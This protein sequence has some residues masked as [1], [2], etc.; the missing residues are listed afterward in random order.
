M[1]RFTRACALLIAPVLA[2]VG[3]TAPAS[4]DDYSVVVT[5][6][7][8]VIFAD[9][10]EHPFNYSVTPPPDASSWKIELAI[11]APDGTSGGSV[12]VGSSS[13]TTGV[14]TATF[15]PNESMAG[16]YTVTGLYEVLEFN[17]GLIAQFTRTPVTPFTVELRLPSSEVTATAS[18]E[19]PR[20]GQRVRVNVEVS[21]ERPAG[22]FFGTSDVGVQL[23]RLKGSKWVGVRGT[24]EV[25]GSAG[26]VRLRFRHVWKG[27][28]KFRV[29]AD[30]DYLG[31][32]SSSTFKLR[33]RR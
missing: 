26:T 1:S 31:K 10:T 7:P 13:P 21:D 24:K 30:L 2:S 12:Y 20:L 8:G 18:D 25:T 15:C 14:A 16:T 6:G 29:R 9:C 32:Q 33:A 27:R 19:T 4:A 5:S 23:Q 3:L 17:G 22:G 28:T 11:Q